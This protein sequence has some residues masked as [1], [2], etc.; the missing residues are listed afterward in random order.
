MTEIL[1][2]FIKI[3]LELI[4]ILCIHS[5]VPAVQVVGWCKE[6]YVSEKNSEGVGKGLRTK[7]LLLSLFLLQEIVVKFVCS[8]Q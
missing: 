1:P 6:M 3:N 8:R 5:S 7:E 4:N 2:L